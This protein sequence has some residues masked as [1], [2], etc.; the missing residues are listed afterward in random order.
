MLRNALLFAA[1][2]FSLTAQPATTRGIYRIGVKDQVIYVNNVSDPNKFATTPGPVNLPPDDLRTY[3]DLLLIGDVVSLNGRPAKGT[4]ISIGRL[5]P[6]APVPFANFAI[7]DIQRTGFVTFWIEL[8]HADGSRLGTLMGAGLADGPA[9]PDAPD[10][11]DVNHG[12]N[13]AITGGTGA[14]LGARG[15]IAGAAPGGNATL[16]RL[17]SMAENPAMRR[18]NGGGTAEWIVSFLPPFPDVHDL[19][20][21]ADRR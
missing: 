19:A 3:M 1:V 2:T 10:G 7:A 11:A 21:L 12:G 5:L 20:E 15:Q 4:L 18:Q 8:Q 17:A 6:T 14:F 9:P 13:A 16:T